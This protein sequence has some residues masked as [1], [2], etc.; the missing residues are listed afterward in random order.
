[1]TSPFPESVRRIALIAPA[2]V[3]APEAVD[4]A[5]ERL[6]AW[7]IEPVVMPHVR[8][9]TQEKY[10]AAADHARA[11][12]LEE[13]WLDPAIDMLLCVRGG[14]GSAHLLPLLRWELLRRRAMPL[15]GYSD[16]TALHL[17]M[18]RHQAG[19]P[20]VGPMGIRLE[21]IATDPYTL[22]RF[23][24][25]LSGEAHEVI[26][27]P[28]GNQP[29]VLRPG[30]AAGSVFAAN[31]AVIVTLCGTGWMPDLTGW[32]LILEDIG[33]PVYRLDRY[34]TQLRQCGILD[35]CAGLVFGDFADCGDREERMVLFRRVAAGFAGPVL[36]DFPF[37]HTFP[38]CSLRQG[39]LMT[40]D[41]QTVTA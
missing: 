20:I 25:V 16:L 32:I 14:F 35:R 15:I 1:M 10:L 13:A 31:L 11:A 27:R 22:N 7:K 33:E 29:E 39:Q 24:R 21:Q 4:Q 9:G 6:R 30:T 40:I 8:A 19:I 12:E 23:R 17:A 41:H 36:T 38:L 26:I 3:A 18:L 5:V 37:G 34:L 2:G 28:D